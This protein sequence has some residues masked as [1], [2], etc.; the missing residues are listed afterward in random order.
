MK[1]DFDLFVIGAG[2]GGVRAARMSADFGA[3]VAIAEDLYLGGTCVNVGCVPKKLLVFASHYSEDIKDAEGF[4]WDVAVNGFNWHT[5]I[6]NKNNEIERLNNIYQQLLDKAGVTT[7]NGRATVLDPH[8]VKVG[9]HSFTTA[10]ILIATGSWPSIPEIPGCEHIITSN[11]AFYL[12]TLPEQIIIVGGGYIAVEFAGIFNGLGVDTTLVY[13]GPLFLRGFD[14]ECRKLLAEELKKKGVCLVFDDNIERIEKTDDKLIAYFRNSKTRDAAR[15]MYAT[16]R[17]PNTSGIGLE[18]AGVELK[19]NGAIVVDDCFRTGVSSI[20]AI[21]DVTDRFNLTP[22][23]ITEGM[24][25][26]KLLYRN[27]PA[28][29]DY[30][31]IPTCIFSQPNF[32]TVGLS[33]DQARD[34]YSGVDVYK[35]GFTHLKSTLSGNREK[36]F[37]K[38]IVD[39]QSG[40]V[41]GAHMIGPDAGEIIQGIAVAIKAGATKEIFDTTIG[42]HPTAAEEFV[43][44]KEPS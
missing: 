4:G 25:L 14:Q 29:V 39:R 26:A 9:D 42:I 20:Y 17:K 15:I 5:L 13:R 16:G 30:A 38:L 18:N 40:R 44:M 3:K 36:V 10:D 35:S 23:A 27:I 1:F 32:A 43:T 24:A 34:K 21:G 22:V 33:E 2:S 28:K 6:K 7:I 31:N 12:D 41:V 8:T 37:M 11:E 19:E